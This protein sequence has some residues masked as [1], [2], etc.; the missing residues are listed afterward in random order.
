M[1]ASIDSNTAGKAV[2]VPRHLLS[3]LWTGVFEEGDRVA[4]RVG[5]DSLRAPVRS[6]AEPLSA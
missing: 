5:D 1:V 2:Q 6:A 4:V 3:L